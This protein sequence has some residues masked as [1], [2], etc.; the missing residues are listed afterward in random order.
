MMVGSPDGDDVIVRPFACVVLAAGKGTRMASDVPKPLHCVCGKPMIDHV[1]ALARELEPDRLIMVL[2]ADREAVAAHLPEVVTVAVQEPQL[3]TG[4]AVASAREALADFEGDVLVT[5]ADIPLLTPTTV[6]KLLAM[7]RDEGASASVLTMLPDDPTGYG[8]LVRDE[9]G[10]VRA[11]VEHRDADDETLAI[12]EVNSSVYCFDARALFDALGRLR[13]DNDQAEY[14]LTDVIRLMVDD[15]LPVRAMPSEDADE[16]MGINTR[17]QLALAERIAR[18]RVRERV[19]LAG[20]TL[21]DPPSTMI[22]A[23]VTIGRDT[24]IGPGSCLLGATTVGERCEIRSNVTLRDATVGDGVLLRDHTVIEIS[25]V[26]DESELGPFTLVRGNSGVGNR[27]K[28]GSSAE[29]NR[30]RIGDG[31]KMQHFSYLGDSDVGERCNIGAGAITCNYDGLGK[32]HTVIEDEV[33]IGSSAVL[34]APVSIERGAY[35][36]AGSVVTKDVPAGA[37]AIERTHQKNIEDWV[38]RWHSRRKGR[39]EQ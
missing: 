16:V 27:C 12:G 9:N 17:V 35:V 1:L 30:S 11:I 3:G 8:R 23:D 20:A 34:V 24:V 18:D 21:L 14:Y 26:G 33:F 10:A 7:H 28:L 37:L 2:G 29:M 32:H 25:S 4:H 15:G 38:S 6:A 19:M 13:P 22:D 39:E 36:A 31:S 5:C